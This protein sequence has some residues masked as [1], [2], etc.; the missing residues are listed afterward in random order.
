MPEM[1][2]LSACAQ[3][4]G[5]KD[6]LSTFFLKPVRNIY[7]CVRP[8]PA[9]PGRYGSACKDSSVC[10]SKDPLAGERVLPVNRRAEDRTVYRAGPEGLTDPTKGYGP[11]K[12]TSVGIWQ[13]CVLSMPFLWWCSR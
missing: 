8:S 12:V 6:C 1:A 5:Q 3:G 11:A 9:L 10:I 2:R 4:A 7:F 13:T